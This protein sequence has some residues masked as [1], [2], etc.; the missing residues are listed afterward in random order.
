LTPHRLKPHRLFIAALPVLAAA[1]AMTAHADDSPPPP[2]HTW[3]GKGQ[4]GF[5]ESKGNSNAESINGNIDFTRYDAP[6]KNEITLL[7]L[8]GKNNGIVSAE[9]FEAREQ[10]NYNVTSNIFA[11]G[12]LRYEHDLF[13]GFEFQRSITAGLGYK[14]FDTKTTAL[15]FQAGAG[16]R[17]I[18]PET[19]N[20][21]QNGNGEVISR[22]PLGQTNEAIGSLEIDFMHKFNDATTLTNKLYG[23]YG[24]MNTMAT[25]QIQLA[26]KMTTKLALVLGYTIID[27]TDPAPG[28]K[29]VDQLTTVNLQFSF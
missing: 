15:S 17:Q 29:K 9:R 7:G 1:A 18:R 8:Y 28:L 6:W 24:S 4:F 3:I 2:E 13:D 21:N 26:V 11:F 23:E 25:D 12:A 10:T 19:L 27:N 5:L 14:V 16:Y 22:I 20:Y